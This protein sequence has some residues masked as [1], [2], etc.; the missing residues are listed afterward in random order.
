M[1]QSKGTG[2][3]TPTLSS[4][5][6]SCSPG[7]RGRLHSKSGVGGGEQRFVLHCRQAH[8]YKSNPHH[9]TLEALAEGGSITRLMIPGATM[10]ENP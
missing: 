2:C 5:N 4:S 10:L 6:G 1:A 3:L 9:P 7:C 8:C